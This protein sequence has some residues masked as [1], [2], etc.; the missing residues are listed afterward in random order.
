MIEQKK[1]EGRD[2]NTGQGEMVKEKTE[3]KKRDWER[4]GKIKTQEEIM[5]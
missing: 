1:S 3:R 5:E 4:E 2:S